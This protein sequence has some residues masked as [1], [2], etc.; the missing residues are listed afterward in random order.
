MGTHE[1]LYELIMGFRRKIMENAKKNPLKDELTLSQLEVLWFIGPGGKRSMESIAEYLSITPPSATAMIAK[2]EKRG[3]VKRVR[4]MEDKRIIFISLA[5]KIKKR[6]LAL[7]EQKARLFEK[8]VSKLSHA[9]R[10][11]LKR[12]IK[13]IITD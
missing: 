6:F 5:G 9:D 2:M 1:N 13:I 7:R 3:I 12:I 11:E 8:L 4:D 10:E